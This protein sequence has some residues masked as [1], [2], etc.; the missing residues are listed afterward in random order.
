[1]LWGQSCTV[2]GSKAVYPDQ[3]QVEEVCT[4]STL[5]T[6]STLSACLQGMLCAIILPA[7]TLAVYAAEPLIG[8]GVSGRK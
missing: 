7:D 5:G 1:M 8:K 4:A 2:I 3:V 6:L